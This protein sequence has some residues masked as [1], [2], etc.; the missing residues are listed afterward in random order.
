MHTRLNS[1][2]FAAALMAASLVTSAAA[3]PALAQSSQQSDVK[4]D[5][6]E[7]KIEQ[8]VQ[9]SMA[10]GEA[11]EEWGSRIQQAEGQEKKRELQQKANEE[12]QEAIEDEGLSTQEYNKIYQAAQQDQELMNELTERIQEAKQN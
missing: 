5:W 10:V 3:T 9:A 2:R 6:S 8:F 11:Q 12:V 4:T 7:Q 1:R